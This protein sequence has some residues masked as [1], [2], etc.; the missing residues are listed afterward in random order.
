MTIDKQVLIDSLSDDLILDLTARMV[1]IP[2][3]NPPGE[4]KPCAEF[5]YETLTGWGIEARL[6]HEPEP[7]R[8]QVVAWIRGTSDGP[9][10]IL[11]GHIDTV[12]EGDP[13]LWSRPPFK[14]TREGDRLYGLGTS[15]MKGSL[16][17]CMA[18]L[19]AIHDRGVRFPGT[20]M[21]QAV[22]GEEMDEPGTK[23]L[24]RLGHTG[25]WA[26]T[27]E[28]TG[29]R[30]GPG[31]RGACWHRIELIGPSSHCG[32]T[33]AD[34]PDVMHFFTHFAAEVRTYHQVV[35]KQTHHL[36]ASP[37][38]R[39]TTVKGGEAH[40]S[41]ARRCEMVID[42][43]MLPHESSE[44]VTSDLR[45]RLEKVKAR[46][47]EVEYRIEFIALNEATE[48]PLDS[49]LVKALQRNYRDLRGVEAEIWG[50]P[51]GSDMRNFMV[52]AGIP[53]LNFGAGDFHRCHQP[54]EF[55][56]VDDLLAVARV[57][58]GTVIDFLESD[59]GHAG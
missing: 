44:T 32:L 28:P 1:A 36:L 50:P 26:I 11:N 56:P 38:C 41:T 53:T 42:R 58:F 12:A 2:T 19:K 37:A 3:R 43:R 51:Y 49:P 48:T 18:I 45:E 9:T 34:A 46:I 57:V 39:I 47:P 5:I 13:A 33:A 8:P 27:M 23:T 20:L 52:D 31:T 30:I 40:N 25:D 59:R 17:S 35:A 21:F 14:A 7:E 10:F 16:A 22:M 4:E 6:V 29:S 55:V 15:D 24:L 54:D